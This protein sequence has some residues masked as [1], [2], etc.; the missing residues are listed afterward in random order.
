LKKEQKFINTILDNI[1]APVILFDREG[2]IIR[3]NK[4]F[5]L[6]TDGCIEKIIEPEN[7]LSRITSDLSQDKLNFAWSGE[8]LQ[9][10]NCLVN[11]DGSR[12]IFTWTIT[13]FKNSHASVEYLICIG[14]DVTVQRTAEDEARKNTEF[15]AR[16]QRQQTAN[17]LATMLAHE[18]NQP[19]G[20]IS[21]Y[22][23]AGRILINGEGS[24]SEKIRDTLTQIA[25][26]AQRG[27]KII[28]HMRNFVRKT[29]EHKTLLDLNE[30]ITNACELIKG[31]IVSS[32]IMLDLDLNDAPLPVIGIA[33]HIEQVLL[34]LIINAIEAIQD[35]KIPEGEIKINTSLKEGM[36]SVSVLDNGTGIDEETSSK[37][38][39][40]LFTTKDYGLGVGLRIS[41]NLIENLDGHLWVSPDPTGGRFFF[42][43]PIAHETDSLHS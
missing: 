36:A 26:Q 14:M 5:D 30:V 12:H 9:F 3:H 41:R 43:L 25:E 24:C 34:N 2:Q 10:E 6:A 42:N 17:E 28:R 29:H 18:L 16:M 39:N 23:D 15:A 7:W 21:A 33:L 4:A 37:I 11:S 22:A 19:L 8:T 35:A 32:K 31:K 13:A 1:P 38:F 20:A 40:G 27:G